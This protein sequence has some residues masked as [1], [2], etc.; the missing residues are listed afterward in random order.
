MP[1]IRSTYF[2]SGQTYNKIRF[3]QTTLNNQFEVRKSTSSP[4]KTMIDTLHSTFYS[5]STRLC[6]R[7]CPTDGKMAVTL[8]RNWYGARD[9]DHFPGLVPQSHPRTHTPS[10]D[11]A[12]GGSIRIK[13]GGQWR[14]KMATGVCV[15]FLYWEVTNVSVKQRMYDSVLVRFMDFI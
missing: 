2:H 1:I 8:A 9:R 10:D 5:F 4:P 15:F 14:S 3:L 13:V 12:N 6:P 11:R 7:S